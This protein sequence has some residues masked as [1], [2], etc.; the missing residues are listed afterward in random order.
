MQAQ[1]RSFLKN[2]RGDLRLSVFDILKQNQ[3]IQRNVTESYIE[4]VQ[5]N[6]LQRYFMLTF[7]YKI[8]HVRK[9]NTKE[10]NLDEGQRKGNDM[11]QQRNGEGVA[12]F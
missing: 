4:D 12:S 8:N 2:Q 9:G 5:T 10:L 6:V 11:Q 3:S 7:T 1:E